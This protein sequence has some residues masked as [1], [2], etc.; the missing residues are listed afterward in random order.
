MEQDIFFNLDFVSTIADAC[1]NA[2][3]FPFLQL[4]SYKL[5]KPNLCKV[6]EITLLMLSTG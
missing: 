5:S 3:A 1:P 4:L 2:I 6:S